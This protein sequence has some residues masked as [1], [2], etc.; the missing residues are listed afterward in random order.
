M[1]EYGQLGNHILSDECFAV[2]T[3]SRLASANRGQ[4]RCWHGIQLAIKGLVFLLLQLDQ[5]IQTDAQ[6][7]F[8]QVL[9]VL[10]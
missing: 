5:P 7:P 2:T 8:L 10:F 9:G 1:D 6:K 3:E 4:L